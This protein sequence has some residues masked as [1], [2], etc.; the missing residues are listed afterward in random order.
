M[1]E[2]QSTDSDMPGKFTVPRDIMTLGHTSQKRLDWTSRLAARLAA[3]VRH[4]AAGN[5]RVDVKVVAK[6]PQ[7]ISVEIL[8]F[9]QVFFGNI[10]ELM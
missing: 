6:Q 2:K 8:Q 3:L 10:S 7:I 4:T 9:H 1:S 5:Q